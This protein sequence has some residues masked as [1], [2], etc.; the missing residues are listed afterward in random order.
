MCNSLLKDGIIPEGKFNCSFC[1]CK[2]YGPKS[3]DKNLPL[4]INDVFLDFLDSQEAHLPIY[5]DQ[6]PSELV[7]WYC[8]ETKEL[9]SNL[10][11]IKH[12]NL[13]PSC[14]E[15]IKATIDNFFNTAKQSLSELNH[16]IIEILDQLLL[17]T[18]NDFPAVSASA[19]LAL[20]AR[21]KRII[22][23]SEVVKE[24]V[25][26]RKDFDWLFV[27]QKANEKIVPQ[28]KI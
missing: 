28:P 17:Y 21:T 20:I 12:P 10:A 24:E 8:S 11:L 2:V 22:N 4:S 6:Y 19:F 15:F 16:T 3:L 26:E 14:H 13:I 27:Q 18:G 25:K 1:Q 7:T 9:F 5:C 23:L